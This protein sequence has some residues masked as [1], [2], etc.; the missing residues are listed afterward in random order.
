MCTRM[1]RVG[2]FSRRNATLMLLSCFI[3]V[4]TSN[5]ISFQL[6]L[7][8]LF[9]QDCLCIQRTSSRIPHCVCSSLPTFKRR[10]AFGKY[11]FLYVLHLSS[12]L[13]IT[14]LIPSCLMQGQDDGRSSTYWTGCYLCSLSRDVVP[15]L[16]MVWISSER[17]KH[18]RRPLLILVQTLEPRDHMCI[19]VCISACPPRAFHLAWPAISCGRRECTFR[20]FK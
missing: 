14:R 12:L 11:A 5:D 2:R 18:E 9:Q 13:N 4:T 15:S 8:K 7:Y 3:S 6:N 19:T 20:Q 16:K 17:H 1:S 10:D